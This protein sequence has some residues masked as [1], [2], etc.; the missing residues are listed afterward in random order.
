MMMHRLANSK[1]GNVKRDS[2]KD[3]EQ[4]WVRREIR[5][6]VLKLYFWKKFYIWLITAVFF[7]S[8]QMKPQEK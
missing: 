1:Y 6:I 3:G 4:V 8:I 2:V 5:K 7:E